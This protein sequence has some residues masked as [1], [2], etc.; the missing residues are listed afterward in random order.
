MTLRRYR[1]TSPGKQRAYG[2]SRDKE[3]YAPKDITA[4]GDN[5]VRVWEQFCCAARIRHDGVMMPV[6]EQFDLLL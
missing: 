2:S 4:S 6:S 3:A 1:A 5:P